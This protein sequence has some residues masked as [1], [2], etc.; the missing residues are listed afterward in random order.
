MSEEISSEIAWIGPRLNESAV[1]EP[2]GFKAGLNHSTCWQETWLLKWSC[3]QFYLT[4]A[5]TGDPL[6]KQL[7][8]EGSVQCSLLHSLSW[9]FK[10]FL[11]L[12]SLSVSGPI[13]FLSCKALFQILFFRK[14]LPN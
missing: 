13:S 12:K 6:S 5:S 10:A 2:A 4:S 9:I 14:S 11:D 7:A 8:L 1:E 3:S